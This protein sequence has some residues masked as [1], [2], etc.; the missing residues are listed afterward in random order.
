MDQQSAFDTYSLCLQLMSVIISFI[1]KLEF[2]YCELLT[3]DPFL[4][5]FPFECFVV[6]EFS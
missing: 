5:P 1:L 2:R 3:L 4:L 6:V